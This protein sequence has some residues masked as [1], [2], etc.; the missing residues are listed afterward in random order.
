LLILLRTWT[1]AAFTNVARLIQ[2]LGVSTASLWMRW[3]HAKSQAAYKR[4]RTT[5]TAISPQAQEMRF[6][7]VIPAPPS[8]TTSGRKTLRTEF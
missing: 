3:T 8:V 5:A 4:S 7:A 2:G 6:M 1:S